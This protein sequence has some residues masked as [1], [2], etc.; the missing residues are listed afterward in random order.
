MGFL[1][2]AFRI[3]IAICMS[4]LALA[5]VGWLA[6]TVY[7]QKQREEAR[8]FEV[9]RDWSID[10]STNLGMRLVAKTKVVNGRLYIAAQFDGYPEY[11]SHPELRQK[12]LA[13]KLNLQFLDVDGFKVYEKPTLLSQWSSVV[14][15]NGK[16]SGLDAQFD[17]HI[18]LDDYKRFAAVTVQWHLD[19]EIPKSSQKPEAVD[20]GIADHCAP[21]IARAER[22]R[23]LA[24]HGVVRETGVGSYSAGNKTLSLFEDGSVLHCD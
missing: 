15:P 2:G 10:L 16:S 7:E 23:R 18:S 11:L 4:A 12:N 9:L 3:A 6:W 19:T 1:K 5:A 17:E 20:T 21:R 24:Q 22:L 13:G 8:Q 14:D